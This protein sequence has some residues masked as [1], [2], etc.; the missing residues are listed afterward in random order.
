V[1]VDAVTDEQAAGVGTQLLNEVAHVGGHHE[2][3]DRQ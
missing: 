2:K 3:V 1:L